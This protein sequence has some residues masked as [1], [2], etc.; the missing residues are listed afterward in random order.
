MYASVNLEFAYSEVRTQPFVSVGVSY[1]IVITIKE[2]LT[3]LLFRNRLSADRLWMEF[4]V[5]KL[6]TVF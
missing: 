2:T 3:W 4:D 6:S 1:I 5:F